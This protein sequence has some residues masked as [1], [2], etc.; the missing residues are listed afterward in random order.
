M[1]KNKKIPDNQITVYETSDGK[2]NIEVLYAGENIWLSQK[3]MS[4]LFDCSK[5][6]IS[7]HLKNIYSEKELDEFSTNEDYSVVQK[8][9]QREV[10]RNIKLYSLEAVI[11]VGYRVN[12]DRGT[13]FRQWAITILK[14]YIHKGFALDSN[15]FK[16]GSRFS[17][18]FFDDLLEE[19]RDIRSSERMVYQKI[20]DIYATSIDYTPKADVTKT[21]FATVQ[22]KLH[23]AITGQTAAEI[24]SNRADSK[25]SNMGLTSWRKS[26]SGKV[27]PSDVSIAKNYLD[28]DE[29]DHLNRIVTMYLD[30]A[31]L[32]AIRN[33]PM[34]MKEWVEKLNVFLKFSEYDI[35]N[36]AGTVSHEVALEL[37]KK[38]YEEF[39][40]EQDKNYLSDFDKQ[41]KLLEEERAKYGE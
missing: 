7:L 2:I 25:K 31:E 23:F 28:K 29:L 41:W 34:Y 12:S 22:N 9:G 24:I 6:N 40:K 16:Y 14:E 21:F 32:Q 13:Q 38:E 3:Q 15:R 20:T 1:K 37:A 18:R 19:I 30:F 11:A 8:E 5:D 10:K 27:M 35:L 4:E 17:A 39:K 26:P 36:N 33:K